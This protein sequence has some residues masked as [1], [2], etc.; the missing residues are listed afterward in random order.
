MSEFEAEVKKA[1]KELEQ[2]LVPV[3]DPFGTEGGSDE[4][5]GELK[6]QAQEYGQKIQD[7]AAKARDLAS[8]KFTQAGDKIKE[9]SA[10]DPKE[11]VEDAKE[12]ARQKPGQT[13]LISAAV[14]LVLGLI[15]RGGR[16]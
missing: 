15:L 3:N 12:F 16:K 6:M 11:L 10:K 5:L 2:G 8:E 1:E 13:I 9:L 14:G 7:A 4:F